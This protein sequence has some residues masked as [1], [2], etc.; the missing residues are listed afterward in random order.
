MRMTACPNP[1]QFHDLAAHF[2]AL[3]ADDRFLRF[4]LEASDARIV[5]YVEALLSERDSVLVVAEPDEDISGVL[6]VE[7][8]DRGATMGLS[9][10]AWAR[11][12]GIG[13]AL[14]QC[15]GK[16]AN[17]RGIHTL[18][19]RK[20]DF[21]GAL[22]RLALRL[23][24][25]VACAADAQT[26]RIDVSTAKHHGRRGEVSLVAVTLADDALRRRWGGALGGVPLL[27]LPLAR[28]S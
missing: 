27:E 19:V 15:A 12:R 7:S 17:A 28:L 4:G 8:R 6:H 22:Q 11:G 23:G 16:M 26:T 5:Q 24:M 13:S 25:S 1:L 2:L 3:D 10:S 18:F 21:N 20:L 9:V 14:L